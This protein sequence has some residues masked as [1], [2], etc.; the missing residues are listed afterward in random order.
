MGSGIPDYSALLKCIW[1]GDQIFHYGYLLPPYVAFNSCTATVIAIR[2][3]KQFADEII[4]GQHAGVLL[5]KTCF[6]AEQGGQIYDVGF[7]TRIGDEVG[8]GWNS[9]GCVYTF[10][11]KFLHDKWWLPCMGV[12]MYFTCVM[13]TTLTCMYVCI[14][15]C[16]INIY[17]YLPNY[18]YMYLHMLRCITFISLY[19]YMTK[20]KLH[21]DWGI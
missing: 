2:H 18:M 5:D 3:N 11:C 13:S 16:I 19:V 4:D 12:C 7:I 6:Y 9:T 20:N 15:T 21:I 8:Y 10:M 14:H 1:N 17:I